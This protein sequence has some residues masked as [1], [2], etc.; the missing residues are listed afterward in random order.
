MFEYIEGKIAKKEPT[1]AIID[2]NGVGYQIH[3]PVT[4]YESLP[5][6]NEKAKLLIYFHVREDTQRLYGFF[7]EEERKLFIMLTGISGIGPKT[8]ITMLSGAS[9]SE[10]KNRIITQN[11]KALTTIPGIGKKTAKRI[12]MEL[13]EKIDEI[14]EDAKEEFVS[15]SSFQTTSVNTTAIDALM[16]LGYNQTKA[17]R[18][19]SR[20]I[21]KLGKEASVQ[22]YIKYALS[23]M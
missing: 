21:N 10:F 4:T 5:E 6:I 3:I 13:N 9:P 1:S 22:D 23:N 14:P 11:V 12:I 17:K 15:T 20:A 2:V 8:A 16:E 7:T 19:V 18:A